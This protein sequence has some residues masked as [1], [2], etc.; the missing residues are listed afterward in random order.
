MAKLDKDVALAL[1]EDLGM[2]P[3]AI[4]K[5]FGCSPET[6]RKY[7]GAANPKKGGTHTQATTNTKLFRKSWTKEDAIEGGHR[8]IRDHGRPPTTKEAED[9]NRPEY[10]INPM[11]ARRLFGS[12][13]EFM[14]EL[15][16]FV[17]RGQNPVKIV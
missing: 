10:L 16:Y 15:G 4:A 17:Q 6:V 11:S 2:G 3:T 14:L 13:A 1:R 12:W 7:I 9:P 5:Y 8:F